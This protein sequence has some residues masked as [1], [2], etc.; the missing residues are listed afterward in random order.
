MTHQQTKISKTI[1]YALRHRP[2]EFGL[3]LDVEGWVPIND[4]TKAASSNAS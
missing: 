1:S 2:D 4:L 3:K